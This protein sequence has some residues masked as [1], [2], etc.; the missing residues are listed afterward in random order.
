MIRDPKHTQGML[1]G[2]RVSGLYPNNQFQNVSIKVEWFD[3]GRRRPT[4]KSKKSPSTRKNQT[5]CARQ[6]EQVDFLKFFFSFF[7]IL[8]IYIP[9]LISCTFIPTQWFFPTISMIIFTVRF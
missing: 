9:K 5:C 4:K 2:R 3:F 8:Y 1:F 6:S 7:Y